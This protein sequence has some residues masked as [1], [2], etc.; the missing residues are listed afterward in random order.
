MIHFNDIFAIATSSLLHCRPIRSFSAHREMIDATIDAEHIRD[1][2]ASFIFNNSTF[3]ITIRLSRN[4][5][6]S[7]ISI[8][9]TSFVS[10]NS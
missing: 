4:H 9:L 8:S 6:N 10:S 5:A 1:I 3:A 7:A 2:V